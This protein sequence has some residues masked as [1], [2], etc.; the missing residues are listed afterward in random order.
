MVSFYLQK[1]FSFMRS[2][3]LIVLNA[4]AIG[5]LFSKLSPV[6]MSS[7]IFPTSC[8]IDSVYLVLCWN[9]WYT[10]TWVLCMVINVDAFACLLTCRH[11][12]IL[13]TICWR[14][15]PFS[16]VWVYRLW[17]KIRVCRF[18]DVEKKILYIVWVHLLSI[19]NWGLNWK[20]QHARQA[21]QPGPHRIKG[22]NNCLRSYW[23]MW[24]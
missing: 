14:C 20:M 4:W 5:V 10:W 23:L 16:I 13:A 7:R 6:P 1:L 12:V 15:C 8:S 2:H 3:L 19:K 9:L 18:V 11:Q 22:R 21:L 24:K 17:E